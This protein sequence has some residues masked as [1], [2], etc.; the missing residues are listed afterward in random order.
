MTKPNKNNSYVC[1]LGKMDHKAGYVG[2][3]VCIQGR[4]CKNSCAEYKS[5]E[6]PKFK[7]V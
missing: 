7:R 1:P 3:K 2:D 4:Y 6:C 5:N